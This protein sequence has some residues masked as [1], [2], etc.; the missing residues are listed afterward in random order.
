M[1]ELKKKVLLD[2]FVS[3]W[4]IVPIVGGLSAWLISWG[5][6]G[7]TTLN[8]L[9]LVGVLT[10]VGIQASRLIFGLEELTQKA[11]GYLTEQQ[12]R[13]RE[14]R[15]DEL[16]RRLEQDEDPRSEECLMKLRTLYASL[17]SE[18][19]PR[20][21]AYAFREQVDA[22][23]YAA[24]RQLERSLELWEKANRL[25]HGAGRPLLT[26][27]QK[28]VD[29]VVETVEHLASTVQQYHSFRLKDDDHELSKLR[30]ELDRTMEV[31]RRAEQV[32]D[33]ID[34]P[35]DHD[36]AKYER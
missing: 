23:F 9:G 14:A 35:P 17:E 13:E 32:M 8:L 19:N 30:Q 6:D 28:A 21:T 29:E 7:N 36:E 24:I 15:L 11:Y 12:R 20:G 34:A 5:V 18:T 22:L 10:G 27:R 31:A 16:S 26:E 3:P 4:T 1:D 33:S 2:L 25:P